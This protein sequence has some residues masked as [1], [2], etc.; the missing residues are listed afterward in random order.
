MLLVYTKGPRLVRSHFEINSTQPEEPVQITFNFTLNHKRDEEKPEILHVYLNLTAGDENT[1]FLVEMQTES[2]FKINEKNKSSKKEIAKAVY[3]EAG[4][5]IFP[6]I[7]EFFLD[8][9]RKARLSSLDLPVIDFHEFYLR[10]KD[11]IKEKGET[12]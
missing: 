11:A 4:P 9:S 8:L 5:A 10:H 1:P 2:L 7:N 3:L 6:T 12:E